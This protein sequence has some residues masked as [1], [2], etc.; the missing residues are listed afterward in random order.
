MKYY[1]ENFSREYFPRYTTFTICRFALPIKTDKL[2]KNVIARYCTV[3]KMSS[4][5]MGRFIYDPRL[6]NFRRKPRRYKFVTLVA[7]FS[8]YIILVSLAGISRGVCGIL[9]KY[10]GYLS[11]L[12]LQGLFMYLKGEAICKFKSVQLLIYFLRGEI[13][14]CEINFSRIKWKKRRP[15]LWRWKPKEKSTSL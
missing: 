6:K 9:E 5:L 4:M 2:F 11:H 13:T 8:S 14:I 7:L 15:E 1:H 10:R 3:M 12:P